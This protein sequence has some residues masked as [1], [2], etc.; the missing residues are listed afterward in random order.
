MK[1][2]TPPVERTFPIEIPDNAPPLTYTAM[3][4]I[5]ADKK[6]ASD[7]TSLK[8]EILGFEAIFAIT[9]LLTIAYLVRRERYQ[10]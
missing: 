4:V 9:V 7:E 10:G 1:G 2:L 3:L 6:I 8:V 5:E